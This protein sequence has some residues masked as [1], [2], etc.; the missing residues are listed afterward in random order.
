M[1]FHTQRKSSRLRSL[2]PM[3]LGPGESAATSASKKKT[4]PPQGPVWIGAWLILAFPAAAASF[5]GFAVTDSGKPV[6][7]ATVHWQ[8]Q[9]VCVPIPPH[10]SPFCYPPTV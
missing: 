2:H 10:G 9:G 3:L 4:R 5:G 1:P 8:N 7:G 6:V